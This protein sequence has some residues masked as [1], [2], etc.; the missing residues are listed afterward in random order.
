[1]KMNSLV[2]TA[3]IDALYGASAA[4]VPDRPRRARHLLPAPGVPGLSETIRVRSIVGE[5]LEH[6]RIY[7]FGTDPV[8][9]EYLIGS[10][11]LM[12]RNLDRR[13]EAI[14]PVDDPRLRARLARGARHQPRRRHARVGARARR[15]LV[16]GSTAAGNDTQLALRE[17][18]VAART[19][20]DATP[21]WS[22]S[23]S[24]HPVRRSSSPTSRDPAPGVHADEPVTSKLIAAY[25]DTADLRL[26]R[27]GREPA[28]P[29]RRGMDW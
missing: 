14:V 24:S 18:A 8:E 7:R 21:C 26:A 9:A 22:A 2:D 11:D 27:V 3:M 28:P 4:G 16:D 1:M 13:V 6:S 20:S 25:F 17:L 15:H 23:S 5:F 10:A 29:Q 12:P 19:V